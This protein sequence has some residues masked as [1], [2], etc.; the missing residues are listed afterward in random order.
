MAKLGRGIDDWLG[1]GSRVP[2]D[3]ATSTHHGP[4]WSTGDLLRLA[5]GWA[6]VMARG[7]LATSGPQILTVPRYGPFPGVPAPPTKPVKARLSEAAEGSE[8]S[9]CPPETGAHRKA[10]EADRHLHGRHN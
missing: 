10:A 7:T 4:W 8:F 1:G 6:V 2:F 3:E 5:K 9:R